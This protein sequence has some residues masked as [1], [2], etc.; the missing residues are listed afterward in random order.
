[1]CIG[2]PPTPGPTDSDNSMEARKSC[3]MNGLYPQPNPT[4]DPFLQSASAEAGLAHASQASADTSAIELMTCSVSAVEAI[5]GFPQRGFRAGILQ[6]SS[7]RR[8]ACCLHGIEAGVAVGHPADRIVMMNQCLAVG[9]DFQIAFD[10][11]ASCDGCDKRR[12]RVL[13]DAFA[14]VQP[15]MRNRP[16]KEPVGIRHCSSCDL[17]NGVHFDCSIAWQGGH[18]DGRARM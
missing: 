4:R 16:P 15:A 12:R 8:T 14:V 7:T 17:E 13:N 18:P 6:R 11:I 3:D 2:C 1:M 9:G 10:A 5:P